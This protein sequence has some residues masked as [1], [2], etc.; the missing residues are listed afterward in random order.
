[1]DQDGSGPRDQPDVYYG[2]SLVTS[3][4]CCYFLLTSVHVPFSHRVFS[5]PV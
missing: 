3:V 5:I 4:D 1:M 2:F